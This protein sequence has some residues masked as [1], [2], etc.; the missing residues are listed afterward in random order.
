MKALCKRCKKEFEVENFVKG[1]TMCPLCG[2]TS[3][4]VEKSVEKAT[5]TPGTLERCEKYVGVC[6][7]CGIYWLP[8][9]ED[10]SQVFCPKCG[11]Q[12]YHVEVL[13]L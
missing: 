6:N 5:D 7:N 12:K 4:V 1:E 3:F 11:T 10:M 2:L 13:M 8:L 9:P